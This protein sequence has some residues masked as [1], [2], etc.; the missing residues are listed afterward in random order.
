MQLV[1]EKQ[2]RVS[3]DP[4]HSKNVDFILKHYGKNI[5]ASN[6]SNVIKNTREKFMKAIE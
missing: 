3:K 6:R 4:N 5:D 2:G 1:G